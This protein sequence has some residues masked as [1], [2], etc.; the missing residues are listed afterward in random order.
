MAGIGKQGWA[1]FFST[2]RRFMY[3]RAVYKAAKGVQP[4][5]F[6]AAGFLR[7]L[8]RFL[9]GSEGVRCMFQRLPG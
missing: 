7:F 3:S 6:L 9:G 5:L 2:S 1:E 4:R 8:V